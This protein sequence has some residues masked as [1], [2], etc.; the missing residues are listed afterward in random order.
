METDM[1]KDDDYPLE[2]LDQQDTSEELDQEQGLDI[3]SES[4][5]MK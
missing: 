4:L 1:T 3:E 5:D 2:E